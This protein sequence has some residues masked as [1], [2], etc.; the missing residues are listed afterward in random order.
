M[1]GICLWGGGATL[2]GGEMVLVESCKSVVLLFFLF[3]L[4]YNISG[5]CGHFFARTYNK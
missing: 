3:Q 1:V 5:G 4:H 2:F